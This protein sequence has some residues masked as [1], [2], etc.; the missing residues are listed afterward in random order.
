MRRRIVIADDDSTMIN[1]ISTRL[2]MALFDVI[3]AES[4]PE[5]VRLIRKSEP[6]AAILDV[7]MPGGTGLEALSI[8][9]ADPIMS[10]L[11]VMMLSGERDPDTVMNAMSAGAD[12]YMVK[13]FNPERFLERVNRLTQGSGVSWGKASPVWEL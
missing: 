12:D 4:G 5:A 7:N 8:L 3:P 11:P 1:L 10:K 6:V 2:S 13:P 9:K